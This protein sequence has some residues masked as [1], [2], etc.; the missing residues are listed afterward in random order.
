MGDQGL[1]SSLEKFSFQVW[2]PKD[3]DVFGIKVPHFSVRQCFCVVVGKEIPL[4]EVADL[5]LPK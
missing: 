2:H 5:M 4:L 1:C 3:S